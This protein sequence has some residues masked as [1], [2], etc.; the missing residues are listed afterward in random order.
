MFKK[1]EMWEYCTEVMDTRD[2][3]VNGTDPYYGTKLSSETI[4]NIKGVQGYELA[5][6]LY[7]PLKP[8]ENGHANGRFIWTFKR[9]WKGDDALRWNQLMTEEN[10]R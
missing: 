10:D 6:H 4:L 5:T 1:R 2:G 8:D 3:N 9:R 7:V